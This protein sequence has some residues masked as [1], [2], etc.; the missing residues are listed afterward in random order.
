MVMFVSD[1]TKAING[2]KFYEVQVYAGMTFKDLYESL[3][4]FEDKGI[5]CYAEA[6]QKLIHSLMSEDEYFITMT[7]MTRKH[8]ELKEKYREMT[9]KYELEKSFIDRIYQLRENA[10]IVFGNQTIEGLNNLMLF[11]QILDQTVK[12]YDDLAVMQGV[13]D[14]VAALHKFNKDQV[15][16]SLLLTLCKIREYKVLSDEQFDTVLHLMEYFC[17]NR[18]LTMFKIYLKRA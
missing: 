17:D 15:E 18:I 1:R 6:N 14:G 10:E 8:F 4:S 12:S 9:R 7:G 11:N 3:Q 13:L 5:H 2:V 16:K